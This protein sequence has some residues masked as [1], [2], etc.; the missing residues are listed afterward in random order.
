MTDAWARRTRRQYAQEHGP[1]CWH[2]R[3]FGGGAWVV[4]RPDGRVLLALFPRAV[5]PAARGMA[6]G[7]LLRIARITHE[8]GDAAG[9]PGRPLRSGTAGYLSGVPRGLTKHD[10]AAWA[11][12]VP[13][14]QAMA[15]PF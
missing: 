1:R 7:A 9:G 11:A 3:V 12:V 2:R 13:L 14:I 4:K 5:P 8:R 10:P 6:R 15:R